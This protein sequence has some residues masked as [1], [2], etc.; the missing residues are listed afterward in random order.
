[1][2]AQD[3]GRFVWHELNTTDPSAAERFYRGITGWGIQPFEHNPS[4]RMWTASG[5]PQGGLMVLP[6]QAKQMGAPP[7][8]LPYLG[9][10]NV[11]ATVR[12]ATTL[13]AKTYVAP[14]DIPNGGRFSVLADP[15]GAVFA[16]HS[17]ANP[18]PGAEGAPK[19][20]EFSWHELVTT[21]AQAAW[22]FYQ[23]LFGWAKMDAMDMGPQG[24]YQ[25]FGR[26]RFMYGGM[27]NKAA[28]VPAPPSWLSYVL[29]PSVDAVLSKV[30]AG[31]GKIVNGPMDVPGNDRV[32]MCVDAQGAAF[33][34]HSKGAVVAKSPAPKAAPSEPKPQPKPQPKAKAKAKPKAK[35][36]AKPRKT[37][38]AKPKA[39]AKAKAKPRAKA[40]PKAK[41]R[42][43]SKPKKKARA[44]K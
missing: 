3:R 33:A 31:G 39:R 17:A 15:Q 1:M 14:Q 43:R 37:A 22:D 25:M 27:Y 7:H 24:T 20:G 9:V 13:G 38:K 34:L 28:N 5:V 4:Y 29:V 32:V 30:T 12:Q 21:D 8:W 41:A 23:A 11:D 19:L 6:E 26:G 42:A 10:E 16:V 40:K 35:A 2:S 18:M 36:K 44:K